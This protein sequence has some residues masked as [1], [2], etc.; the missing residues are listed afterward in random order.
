LVKITLKY[1]YIILTVAV[2]LI[3]TLTADLPFSSV[4]KKESA[5]ISFNETWPWIEIVTD[6]GR[7]DY[8]PDQWLEFGVKPSAEPVSSEEYE[9]VILIL[10][11][12]LG[13]Y[14]NSLLKN[15]L[16]QIVLGSSLTIYNIEYGATNIDNRIYITSQGKQL[17]FSDKYLRKTLHHELSS[18]L[19]RNNKFPFDAWK[20]LLPKMPNGQES[21][22][23]E[24]SAIKKGWK[25]NNFTESDLANGFVSKYGRSSIEN[26]INTYAENLMAGNGWLDSQADSYPIIKRK[27]FLIKEFYRGLGVKI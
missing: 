20:N 5:Q 3:G 14:P 9:R 22:I 13:K 2:L 7:P 6:V 1:K 8:F 10:M 16:Q 25:E 17:G 24:V 4:W 18:I 23:R 27:L 26:D 15:N 21:L 12:E 11:T 19:I